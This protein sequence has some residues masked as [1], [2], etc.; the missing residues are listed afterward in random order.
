MKTG[1]NWIVNAH[2]TTLAALVA[3]LVLSAPVGRAESAGDAAAP[4]SAPEC[5]CKSAKA[6]SARSAK[7]ARPA[8][9]ARKEKPAKA[10]ASEAQPEPRQITG[11]HLKQRVVLRRFPETTAPVEIFD[12]EQIERRGEATLGGFLSRQSIFR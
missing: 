7:N 11:S 4:S 2:R 6:A 8:K 12:R 9:A 10:R 3:G 1:W 5:T